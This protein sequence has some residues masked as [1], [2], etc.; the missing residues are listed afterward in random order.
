MIGIVR[1]L[2]P[3]QLMLI[4]ICCLSTGS[5]SLSEAFIVGVIM[6]GCSVA[7]RTFV[8]A[9]VALKTSSTQPGISLLSLF[10]LIQTVTFTIL[11]A[12]IRF[13]RVHRSSSILTLAA[14]VSIIIIEVCV[15][16]VAHL[17]ISLSL[18]SSHIPHSVI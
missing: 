15:S 11:S 2:E 16:P 9:D 18:H 12:A 1:R 10:F 6:I 3:R 4:A 13:Q 7:H 5:I 17:I 8:A 14:L